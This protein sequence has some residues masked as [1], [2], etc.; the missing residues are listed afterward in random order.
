MYAAF[1]GAHHGFAMLGLLFTFV[2]AALAPL[3]AGSALARPIIRRSAYI[4]AMATTGL[5]GVTGLVVMWLGGWLTFL[6]PWIGLAGVALH[7]VA[8]VRSR[9]A[10]AAGAKGTLLAALAVQVLTLLVV[11]WLMMEKPF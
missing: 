1:F 4:G 11:Y 10:L 5:S 9:K 3:P 6:F 7:G 2:W 8:G